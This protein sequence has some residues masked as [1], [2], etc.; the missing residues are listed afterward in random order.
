[1]SE[2]PEHALTISI[3]PAS[4]PKAFVQRQLHGAID[5]LAAALLSS[6]AAGLGLEDDIA[7]LIVRTRQVLNAI[8]Q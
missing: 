4:T 2:Q 1:M 8:T 7:E 5:S 6:R 3:R